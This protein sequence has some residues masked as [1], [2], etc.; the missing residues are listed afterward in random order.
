VLYQL[1]SQA[2]FVF[3]ENL[4]ITRAAIRGS[5]DAEEPTS[6]KL[7]VD[8]RASGYFRKAASQ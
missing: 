1:E 8:L 7:S 3:V 2:P 4:I 5:G 6:P